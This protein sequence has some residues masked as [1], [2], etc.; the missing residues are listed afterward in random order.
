MSRRYGRRAQMAVRQVSISQDGVI[1]PARS[2]WAERP[3]L[4]LEGVAT[5]DVVLDFGCEA[6][7]FEPR[8]DRR[9][10]VDARHLDAQVVERTRCLAGV[11]DQDQLERRVRNGEISIPRADFGR[12]V[13]NSLE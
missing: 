10:L 7:A 8:P 9:D 11:F 12:L 1:L 3:Y 2:P 6:R 13:S 5:G 4:V